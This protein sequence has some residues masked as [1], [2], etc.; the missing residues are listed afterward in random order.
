MLAMDTLI[1]GGFSYRQ[2]AKDHTHLTGGAFI[3]L[4]DRIRV[5]ISIN[6]CETVERHQIPIMI[7]M[8]GVDHHYCD[9]GR[10]PD[11]NPDDE[12]NKTRRITY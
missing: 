3:N 4:I 6:K 7:K 5:L 9:Y 2:L 1:L 8:I 10:L 11:D 12:F